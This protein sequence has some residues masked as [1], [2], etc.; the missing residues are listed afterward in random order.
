VTPVDQQYLQGNPQ[1]I[2]GDCV[3][4]CVASILDMPLTDV[5]HFVQLHGERWA[6]AFVEWCEAM[7]FHVDWQF[8][9]IATDEPAMLAG[10]SPRVGRHA[11]VIQHGKI[12]HDPHPSRLGLL[13]GRYITWTLRRGVG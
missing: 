5:P 13:D 6:D 2:S 4:A 11:V 10:P 1:G 8:G 7:G 9:F 3:R 12:I